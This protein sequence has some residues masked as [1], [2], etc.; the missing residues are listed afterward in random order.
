[1]E[2]TPQDV[3]ADADVSLSGRLRFVRADAASPALT[4]GAGVVLT[5]TGTA[6]ILAAPPSPNVPAVIN[7]GTIIVAAGRNT[8]RISSQDFLHGSGFD[9]YP[10]TY[11]SGVQL[12]GLPYDPPGALLNEG[13]IRVMAGAMLDASGSSLFEPGGP[14]LTNAGTVAIAGGTVRLDRGVIGGVVR[15]LDNGGTLALG[16]LPLTRTA[17]PAWTATVSGFRAGDQIIY[18]TAG[19]GAGVRFSLSNNLLTIADDAGIDAVLTLQGQPG[20]QSYAVQDFALRQD[21]STVTLT[22]AADAH[23]RFSVTDTWTGEAT[24]AD[25]M[26]YQGPVSYLQW[27]YVAAADTGVAMTANAPNVFLH[28]GAGDDALQAQSGQNVLDG[29][30]GSNFLVGTT[31]GADTLFLDER[32]PAETW[33]TV[34]NFHAGD[35]V[36]VFGW[37]A[38]AAASWADQDGAA[39]YQGATL[40]IGLGGAGAP[41]T[42]SLTLAGLSMTDVTRHVVTTN[43][44][45]GGEAYVMM[46]YV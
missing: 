34:V 41:V 4:L 33:S 18:D 17:G 43:G 30:G 7:D 40:H 3:P 42:A 21:G 25:G 31:A 29:G 44:V 24:V 10:G 37:T 15:F 16:S 35:A 38:G 39:G 14:T 27:Q 8:L 1:M 36:T 9:I 2:L 46:T 20:G 32:A 22:T 45:V 12:G 13:T 19:G 11:V 28:G 23:G 26:A 6:N 5:A